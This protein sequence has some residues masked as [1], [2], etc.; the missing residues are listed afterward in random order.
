MSK[1]EPM[2]LIRDRN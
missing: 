1:T 2:G